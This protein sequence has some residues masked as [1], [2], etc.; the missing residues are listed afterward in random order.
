MQ[1]K[2]EPHEALEAL[3]SPDDAEALEDSLQDGDIAES[4]GALEDSPM[5]GPEVDEDADAGVLCI[6]TPRSD[7]ETL[8]TD[9]LREA[10]RGVVGQ[11]G[12]VSEESMSIDLALARRQASHASV[13]QASMLALGPGTSIRDEF[14]LEVGRS[15]ECFRI[16]S[17]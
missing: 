16:S 12:L 10:A 15:L 13:E 2:E 14:E 5:T 11:Y 6:A 4:P 8:D 3:P 7:M 17:G 9:A 1:S